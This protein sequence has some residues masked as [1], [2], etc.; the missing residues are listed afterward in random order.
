M[1][2]VTGV[3]IYIPGAN[4]T[5]HLKVVLILSTEP[6]PLWRHAGLVSALDYQLKVCVVVGNN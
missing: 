5:G 2:Q 6:I 1:I 3:K 4:I